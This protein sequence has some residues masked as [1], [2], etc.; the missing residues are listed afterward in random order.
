MTGRTVGPKDVHDQSL[1]TCEYIT[2]HGKR[3]S[4]GIIS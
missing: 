1:G 2:L 3:D 4:A